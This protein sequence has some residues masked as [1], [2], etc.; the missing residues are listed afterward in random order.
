[1]P[2]LLGIT[3]FFWGAA[4]NAT[5]V[6]LDY[7]SVGIIT[8][9]RPVIAGAIL[10]VLLP[11]IGGRL[12]RSPRVWGYAAFVGL[13]TTT[14]ALTGLGIGTEYAG[15]AV[16]AVLLNTAPFFAVL[17]AR[18]TLDEKIKLL[19]ALG[20][21]VGFA[22]VV[23]IVLSNPGSMG[24]GGEFVFGVIAVLIG[25]AGHAG[26][27]VL[28]RWMSVRDIK[29]EMWGFTAAQFVCGAVLTIPVVFIVGDPGA[30][31]W[32]APALWGSLAFLGVGSQLIAFVCFF[33]ALSRWTS[34]RVMAWAFLPPVVASVIELLRGN[35]PGTLT[36]VG[37]VVA[38]I[39]VAIVNHPRAEDIPV[40]TIDP[41]EHIA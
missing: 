10:L 26:G 23:I 17:M 6:A 39:G 5:D 11:F 7:T 9:A 33:I 41:E 12:P 28:V 29:T 22:G 16:A 31:Q 36:L 40:P 35:M 13:G 38:V 34:G 19:R 4:F 21:I 3:M 20:L 27:S 15:P 8:I 18:I 24:S 25:A 14:L 2:V 32:S 1:M 37:M 30:T